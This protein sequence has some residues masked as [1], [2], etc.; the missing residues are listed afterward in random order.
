MSFSGWFS[1]CPQSQY[2]KLY[3]ELDAK[4]T[5]CL[6]ISHYPMID[7]SHPCNALIYD[8]R[9]LLQNFVEVHIN[10]IYSEGN[11]WVDLLAKEWNLRAFAM[12]KLNFLPFNIS[13]THFIYI[14]T[15]LYNTPNINGYIFFNTLFKYYLFIYFYSL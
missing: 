14:N 10:H 7:D 4:S 12:V 1:P 3:I 6:I 8:C 15:L 2:S 5:I 13:K 9:S 11:H